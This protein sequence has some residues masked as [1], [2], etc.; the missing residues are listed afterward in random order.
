MAADNW[1]SPGTSGDWTKT[2][3]AWTAGT[4]TSADDVTLGASASPYNVTI[5]PNLNVRVADLEIDKNATLDLNSATL[6]VTNTLDIAKGG[7]LDGTGTVNASEIEGGGSIIA[8][9]G[10]LTLNAFGNGIDQDSATTFDIKANSTLVINGAIGDD[11]I[12]PVVN[13][14]GAGATLNLVADGT[15]PGGSD[16]NIQVKGFQSGDS[17]LVGGES[18]DSLS[19]QIVNGAAYVDVVNGGTVEDVIKFDG[20]YTAGEFKVSN[21]GA[22]D[23]I[24]ICFMAGTRVRTP[25]GEVPVETLKRG[26]VVVSADGRSVPVIWLGKQTISTRFADPLRTLPIRIKA[27]ALD[28]NVPSRDLLVSPDHALLV[29]GA[30][31]H[32]GALVNGSS[33]VRETRVPTT[34][35]YYHVEAEDHSLILAENTPAETFVDN[36]DRLN[37][38]NW[39]EHLELYPRGRQIE[40]LPY[41]RAKSARQVPVHARVKLAERAIAIG[42]GVS[43][44][45]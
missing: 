34:F 45:A 18:G 22:T 1:N 39:A 36:V 42:E 28:E 7:A 23:T 21:S 10:T 37:F 4:P 9:G 11:A 12:T 27:G 17:V 31:I 25:E 13:F 30:L 14:E 19:V 24:T 20:T 3:G 41:P 33:I 44:V 2:P 43:A 38:D 6:N 8:D 32:A 29:Q 16:D 5:D 40:E 35:V 15:I 26:D